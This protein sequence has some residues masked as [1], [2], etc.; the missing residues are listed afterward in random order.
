LDCE[1][2]IEHASFAVLKVR[3]LSAISKF[4]FSLWNVSRRRKTCRRE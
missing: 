3:W 4:S 1:S 2:E